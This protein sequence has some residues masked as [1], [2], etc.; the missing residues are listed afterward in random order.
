MHTPAPWSTNKEG[1]VVYGP[2]HAHP[3]S[4][5]LGVKMQSEPVVCFVRGY[6]GSTEALANAR[7]ISAAPELLKAVKLAVEIFEDTACD[8][9]EKGLQ[10]MKDAIAKAEGR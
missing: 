5:G 3:Q 7:L 1:S 9:S 10:G 2:P 8:V 6:R 4:A